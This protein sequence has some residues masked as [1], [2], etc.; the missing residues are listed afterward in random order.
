MASQSYFHDHSSGKAKGH[1]HDAHYVEST[2]T[3]RLSHDSTLNHSQEQRKENTFTR[4]RSALSEYA[5]EFLGTMALC[6]IGIGVNCQVILSNN[7]LVAALPAGNWTSLSLGWGAAIAIGVWI[8]GGGHINPAVT[9][10]FAAWRGFSWKKVPGYIVAQMLGAL[11]GSAI[12]Y[13]N[14]VHAIDIY[15]G[16]RGIRTMKTAG[17]FGTFPAPFMTAASAFFSEFLGSAM[18]LFGILVMTDKKNAVPA[19]FVP[20]GLFITLFGIGAGLGFETGFALNPARDL[21]PRILTAMVGYGGQVFSTR[22]Q[23]WLWCPIIAGC[24]GAQ[25]ATLVYDLFIYEGTDSV[26]YKMFG[27]RSRDDS[28]PASPAMV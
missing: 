24:L 3:P 1:S 27:P 19:W 20:V 13:G 26:I 8:S 21:G 23:Y 18:L 10:A 5:G 9:L 16:G 11:V 7:P 4:C 28:A 17:A 6:I 15:E 14:Y 25:V 22:N 12:I 2:P